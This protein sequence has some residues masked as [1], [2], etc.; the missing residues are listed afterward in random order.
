MTNIEGEGMETN[1][2]YAEEERVIPEGTGAIVW[3]FIAL[4]MWVAGFVGA[5]CGWFVRGCL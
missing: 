5:A 3:P 1:V 2:M 4:A